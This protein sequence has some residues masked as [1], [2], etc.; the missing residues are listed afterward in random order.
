[1]LLAS[2]KANIKLSKEIISTEKYRHWKD[3]NYQCFNFEGFTVV[4]YRQCNLL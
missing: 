2:L 1:M 3:P 4:Y